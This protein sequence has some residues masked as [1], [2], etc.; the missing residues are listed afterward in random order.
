VSHRLREASV[1]VV[2]EHSV[3]APLIIGGLRA[4]IEALGTEWERKREF[5][6]TVLPGAIVEAVAA[7]RGD[8]AEP[9]D[10][11]TRVLSGRRLG[12]ITTRDDVRRVTR[13]DDELRTLIVMVDAPGLVPIYRDLS[14]A[15]DVPVR[16]PPAHVTLYSSDPAQGIGI[17]SE[18]QLAERAPPL[19][20]AEQDEVRAAMSFDEVFADDAV[21]DPPF[22]PAFIDAVEYAAAVHRGQRHRARD[23]PY[24]AHVLA[25]AA[26]VAEDGGGEVEGIAAL[27]HDAAEDR[28]GESR[29]ADIE[30]RFGPDVAAIVRALSDTLDP[31]AVQH[32]P[33]RARKA[34][35]LAS[36]RRETDARI[37]RVSNADKLHNARTLLAERR[38]HGAEMW[39]L[40]AHG[41]QDEL[42]YYGTLAEIFAAQRPTTSMLVRELVATVALLAA[43]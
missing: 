9:W 19:T 40:H 25:V 26:L 38:L 12:P 41:K 36:L 35:Y 11:V 16:P 18:A 21:G 23:V 33:W 27:L 7:Q 31:G 22:T 5:H 29:L 3:V 37:L 43:D 32:E 39:E 28:G 17:E 4:R 14:A 20:S 30:R 2:A 13:P 6:L 24:T 8:Q 10:A 15:L 42:W 1:H 34:R